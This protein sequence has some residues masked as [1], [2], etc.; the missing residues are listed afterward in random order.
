MRFQKLIVL[1]A[2]FYSFTAM[3]Q[4]EQTITRTLE[5]SAADL[6]SEAVY[7]RLEDVDTFCDVSINGHY[8]S[9]FMLVEIL[10]G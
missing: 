8:V 4:G 6:S 2:L 5:V 3:A 7:L 10:N 1:F 9:R